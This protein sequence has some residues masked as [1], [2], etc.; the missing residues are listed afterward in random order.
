MVLDQPPN[1]GDAL[2]QGRAPQRGLELAGQ[3][4]PGHVHHP[5]TA[6]LPQEATRD[7]V[8]LPLEGDVRRSTGPAREIELVL[9]GS[10]RA[11]CGLGDLGKG[12]K[13]RPR[14]GSPLFRPEADGMN[15][16]TKGDASPRRMK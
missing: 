14:A 7:V 9:L 12:R 5:V 2:E 8:D 10:A 16:R 6:L 13:G 15:G 3:V 11:W 1:Q 4:L